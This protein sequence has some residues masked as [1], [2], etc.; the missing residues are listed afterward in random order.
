MASLEPSTYISFRSAHSSAISDQ[1]TKTEKCT[2][3]PGVILPG[4][5]CKCNVMFV[6]NKSLRPLPFFGCEMFVLALKPS[7]N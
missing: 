2:W 4:C 7:V 5:A 6:I 1:L 3:L